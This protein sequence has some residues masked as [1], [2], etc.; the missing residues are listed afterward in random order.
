VAG[1]YDRAGMPDRAADYYR[2][3]GQELHTV[4]AYREAIAVF[5]R[6]LELLPERA[7]ATRAR[8]L[9]DVGNALHRIGDYPAAEGRFERGIGLAHQACEAR[10]EVDGLSGLGL[11]YRV[12]GR[13][14]EAESHLQRALRLARRAE[15]RRGAAVALYNLG[16]AAFRRGDA[17]DAQRYA[18]ESLAIARAI[19]DRQVA[20]HALRV[21]GFAALLRREFD[22]AARRYDQSLEVCHEI[23]DRRGEASCL[24][25]R[26]EL[27]RKQGDFEAAARD[28]EQSLALAH[29]TGARHEVAISHNN[30]GHAL[31]GL[32]RADG[33]R[34][35]LHAALTTALELGVWPIALEALVGTATLLVGA[36]RWVEA[37]EIVGLV[38]A[39][40]SYNDETKRYAEPVLAGLR[41]NA[42]SPELE[43]A[44]ARG[45]ARDLAVVA[46][47]IVA[48]RPAA[49]RRRPGG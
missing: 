46:D 7:A 8:V 41:E 37:A 10:A 38:M 25:N 2:R 33:A 23:G 29:E 49:P 21:L 18:E 11:A 13:H 6:A 9:V 44:L 4:S 40:P 3:Y 45:R 34:E 19:G 16:D 30:L 32:G 22:V 15:Y 17:D 43:A 26:G 35:S 36:G 1:H 27:A 48:N 47:E 28:F 14:A 42:P 39:H 24:I 5:D 20:A 12:Q 31:L